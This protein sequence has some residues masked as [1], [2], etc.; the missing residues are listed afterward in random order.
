[1]GS[2]LSAS[3]ILNNK[4]CVLLS[5]VVIHSISKSLKD[6]SEVFSPEVCSLNIFPLWIL[7]FGLLHGVFGV[8]SKFLSSYILSFGFCRPSLQSA[9][10]W[11]GLILRDSCN[12]RRL[13]SFR[14][15]WVLCLVM[16]GT[17]VAFTGSKTQSKVFRKNSVYEQTVVSLELTNPR[18]ISEC[19]ALLV[20]FVG[21]WQVSEEAVKPGLGY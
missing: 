18:V 2:T 9:V 6:L 14:S 4:F 17:M 1:M 10:L 11:S 19:R 7:C 5:R 8:S 3:K 16:I 12:S 15:F 20:P 21:S 13:C